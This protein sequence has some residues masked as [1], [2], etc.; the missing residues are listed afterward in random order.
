M[1]RVGHPRFDTR[2]FIELF[3][4][5]RLREG[6]RKPTGEI[7]TSPYHLSV[8]EQLREEAL[9]AEDQASGVAAD[10]FVWAL[11][12][13]VAPYL[14]KLGGVPFRSAR[15][16]WPRTP[17]GRSMGFLAQ[18][19]F[20]DSRDLRPELPADV[21]LVFVDPDNPMSGDAYT[22]EWVALEETDLVA[23]REVPEI[24]V[25]WRPGRIAEKRGAH[26]ELRRFAPLVCHG[27]IHRT[28]DYPG[29]DHAFTAHEQP[30]RLSVL[31]ATKIGGSIHEIQPMDAPS[32]TVFLASVASVQPA[33]DVPYPWANEPVPLTVRARHALPTWKV[34]DMGSTHIFDQAGGMTVRVQSY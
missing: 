6:H 28:R 9:S 17:D 13:P 22:T 1:K 8:V 30:N 24:Q 10:V 33:T 2:R 14:T 34:G 19:S 4:L 25:L 16:P 32:L 11:G 12:E 23:A 7:I 29:R 15:K 5:D 27:V 3:P 31:E 20:V 26:P 18:L 21:L